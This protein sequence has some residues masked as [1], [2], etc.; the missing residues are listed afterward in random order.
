[1]HISGKKYGFTLVVV[2]FIIVVLGLL[3]G[4]M[5]KMYSVQSRSTTLSHQGIRAY[6]AAKSALEWGKNKTLS[7]DTCVANATY[8][9]QEFFGGDINFSISMN[10]TKEVYTEGSSNYSWYRLTAVAKQGEE[11]GLDYVSRKLTLQLVK[12]H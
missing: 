3:G 12:P 4:V 5:V 8:S 9:A 1:M 6:Y 10:C 7:T 11:E 2:I